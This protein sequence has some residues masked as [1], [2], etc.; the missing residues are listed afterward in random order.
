MASSLAAGVTALPPDSDG[1]FVFLGDMPL[2]PPDVPVALAEALARGA[3][4]AAPAFEGR[5]G[6]PVLF[7]RASFPALAKLS[8]DDGARAVLRALGDRLVLVP[9]IDP[10]VLLDVDAQGDLDA[11][12]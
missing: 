8:G 9:T 7:G 11:L 4:A 12:G 2:I 5:R 6:H 1:V 3:G 10:G